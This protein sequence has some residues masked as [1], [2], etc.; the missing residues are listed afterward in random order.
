MNRDAIIDTVTDGVI[1]E[2]CTV[3]LI[4]IP[5]LSLDMKPYH[6]P[7]G[8]SLSQLATLTMAQSSSYGL[9]QVPR[10]ESQRTLRPRS[11]NAA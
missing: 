8:L 3:A 10:P 2:W 1:H 4:R 5:T 11:S 7:D 6:L 9:L